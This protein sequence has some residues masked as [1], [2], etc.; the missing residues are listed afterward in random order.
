ME[1]PL[2]RKGKVWREM[3]LLSAGIRVTILLGL[4]GGEGNYESPCRNGTMV[5]GILILL[6]KSRSQ[7]LFI[8]D[9]PRTYCLH[10]L[11]TSRVSS[12]QQTINAYIHGNTTLK[13]SPRIVTL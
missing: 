5:V 12:K 6:T 9:L 11:Y 3:D 1:E 8:Y 13:I 4:M 10:D 7:V 2:G